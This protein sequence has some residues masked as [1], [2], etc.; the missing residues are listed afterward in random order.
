MNYLETAMVAAEKFPDRGLYTDNPAETELRWVEALAAV[1]QAQE[2]R[3][4]RRALEAQTRSIQELRSMIS[5][6]LGVRGTVEVMRYEP[7]PPS[8]PYWEIKE[9]V[10]KEVDK[11]MS[12]RES[13]LWKALKRF[14]KGEDQEEEVDE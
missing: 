8:V 11:E 7:P 6:I 4:S 5:R 9:Y 10:A 14:T 3:K 12:Q 2:A 13:V 1:A